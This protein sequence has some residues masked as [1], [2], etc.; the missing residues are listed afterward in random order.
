MGETSRPA[1][2]RPA[3]DQWLAKFYTK[4]RQYPVPRTGT[5]NQYQATI[6]VTKGH[7]NDEIGSAARSLAKI[8]HECPVLSTQYPV[9]S[10]NTG[11]KSEIG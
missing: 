5:S 1:G 3:C 8:L 11:D 9:P 4:A 6:Q 10:A 2:D 7:T